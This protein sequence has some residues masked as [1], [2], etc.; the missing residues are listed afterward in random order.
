MY[1]GWVALRHLI[2]PVTLADV[3][4]LCGF[5]PS[6]RVQR[7]SIN[8][9][10]ITFSIRPFQHPMNSYRDLEFLIEPAQAAVEKVVQERRENIAKKALKEGG[11][12]AAQAALIRTRHQCKEAGP[13][14]ASCCKRI[15]KTIIYV[16]SIMHIYNMV[17][18]LRAMLV[19]AG[20]SNSSAINA[21]QAYHSELVEFD[22]R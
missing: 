1:L 2:L 4:A 19:Q 8:R 21:V 7:T 14:S 11:A 15:P 17:K 20:C 22:K 3:R 9:H 13:D 12:I 6:V 10:D 5:D 16:D 18:V